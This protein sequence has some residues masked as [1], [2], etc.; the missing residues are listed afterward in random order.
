MLVLKLVLR[1]LRAVVLSSNRLGF[2]VLFEAEALGITQSGQPAIVPG[3]ASKSE[4]IRRLHYTDTEM[5]MPYK[6]P[7]LSKSEIKIL[8]D[9]IDQGAQWGTHW[10]YLPV[11]KVETPLTASSSSDNFIANAIDYFVAT[12]MEDKGLLPNPSAP[13][14][15]LARR[16]SFDITGLPPDPG[17]LLSLIH[18]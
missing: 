15:I 6:K 17:H 3:N 12:R 13:K 11:E 14:N 4:L 10:A 5:R 16:L 8:T 9:W 18:I 1:S 7:A 2:S